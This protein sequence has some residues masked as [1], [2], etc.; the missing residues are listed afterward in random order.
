M[1]RFGYRRAVAG[2]GGDISRAVALAASQPDE[3]S[4]EEGREG[5]GRGRTVGSAVAGPVG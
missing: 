2:T 5:H 1:L 3:E 4:T